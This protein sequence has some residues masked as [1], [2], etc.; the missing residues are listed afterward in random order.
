MAQLVLVR[1]V[2]FPP[3][4]AEVGLAWLRD[5]MAARERAGMVG[6]TI[7]RSRTDRHDYLA[8]MVWPDQ[9][10]YQA[11]HVSEDRERL[12]GD[13]PHYLVREPTRRY[14]LLDLDASETADG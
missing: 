8:V 1:P 12:F 2:H 14:E 13:Q 9:A 7:M 11:W 10:T 5:A 6:H 4:R 3:G